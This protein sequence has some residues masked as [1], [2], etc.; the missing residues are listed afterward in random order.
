MWESCGITA[1]RS[2]ISWFNV[3]MH[4]SKLVILMLFSPEKYFKRGIAVCYYELL[5]SSRK[6]PVVPMRG[7]AGW[8]P[9]AFFLNYF[10]RLAI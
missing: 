8:F 4:L 2:G 5:K 10:F 1:K 9:A 7:A 3:F 6:I